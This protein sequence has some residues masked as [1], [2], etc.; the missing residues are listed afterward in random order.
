MPP[1][2]AGLAIHDEDVA[3][4]FG[5]GDDGR[6]AKGCKQDDGK[7]LDRD[8]CIAQNIGD[9]GAMEERV[10]A[11]STSTRAAPPS[12]DGTLQCGGECLPVDRVKNIVTS[13]MD[14]SRRQSRRSIERKGGR[15][16]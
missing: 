15:R 13:D 9:G 14:F 6:D 10:P 2:K 8:L 12:R 7:N 5:C 3:I 4:W 16:R 1:V 11:E